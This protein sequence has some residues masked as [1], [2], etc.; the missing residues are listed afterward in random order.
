MQLIKPS[1]KLHLPNMQR[2]D[3]IPKPVFSVCVVTYLA[4]PYQVEYFNKIANRDEIQLKVI[5]LRT[6]NKNYPWG[7]VTRRHEH[8]DIE[9]DPGALSE[10]FEWC[11]ESSLTV[12]NYYTHCFALAALHLRHWSGRPWV[13]WGESPGFLRLGWLGRMGRKLLLSPI[14]DSESP[15]WAVGRKGIEGYRNDWGNAKSYVNLPYFSNLERFRKQPRQPRSDECC[16]VYSG[17]LSYRKGV[18]EL[19]RAFSAAA[20]KNARLRLIIMGSGVLEK[21][22]RKILEP[23]MDFVTWE[24][25]RQWQDLPFVYSRA[26]VLCLPTRHDGWAMVV[27]EALASGL[28]VLTTLDA[29][30][31]VELIEDGINGWVMPGTNVEHITKALMHIASISPDEFEKFSRS[32]RASVMN[33]N[34]ETGSSRFIRA[35]HEAV[36]AFQCRLVPETPVRV[37][38]YPKLLITG[39]YGPDC[40]NSMSRYSNLVQAAAKAYPG[41][42]ERIDPLTVIGDFKWLPVKLNKLLGYVDKYIIY[43]AILR[44]RAVRASRVNDCIIHLTDQ[45]LGLVIPWIRDFPVIVTCHDLIAVRGALGEIPAMQ[46]S[47]WRG[48]FQRLIL[49]A[50]R[51]PSTIVS[52][53]NKTYVDC[54]RLLGVGH[55]FRLIYNPLDPEF[56]GDPIDVEVPGL[57]NRFILHVGNSLWYKNRPGV[58]K[59]Y[60]ALLPLSSDIPDIVLMGDPPTDVEKELCNELGIND[61]V[62][63]ISRPPGKWIVAGYD[64]ACL[65]LFPSLEEGF[66]WPLL[67][68]MSR[69]CPVISSNR[70]PLSEIGADAAIYVDPEEHASAALVVWEFLKKGDPERRKYSALGRMRAKDFSLEK[71]ASE[72][73]SV[74]QA[75]MYSG[76]GR[77]RV[78]H[79]NRRDG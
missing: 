52:I 72:W 51:L 12:F 67:E 15:I 10:A 38:K 7:G 75:A 5:Y 35:A 18:L 1:S 30:A 2:K 40:L 25:F 28:P 39:T 4:S 31:A 73:L 46:R 17:I 6:D 43:P 19:A 76:L 41:D 36:A 78:I 44:W 8:C 45:G 14:A 68:A 70:Q 24:G 48:L 69:G 47:K 58:L 71:F 60:A 3:A 16:I 77:S 61:R 37:S 53:S 20:Q 23:V 21:E 59:I 56:G 22:M 63:W 74:Y 79:K 65:L 64:R 62:L 66:G 49:S 50:L 34:L 11:R 33:H 26:H 32:A 13:F 9:G 57:P 42:V 54:K 29:G 55:D 27:P